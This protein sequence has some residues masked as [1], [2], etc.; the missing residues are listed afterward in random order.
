MA[1][2]TFKA[3]LVPNSDLG[4]SL[5]S[6]CANWVVRGQLHSKGFYGT[7]DID[8]G[9]LLPNTGSEG[10]IFKSE[11]HSGLHGRR[12]EHG[13]FRRKK[14]RCQAIFKSEYDRDHRGGRYVYGLCA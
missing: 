14:S 11:A 8:Y 7:E 10:Q 6:T 13:I 1:N 5:G 3:N 2:M 4:Y 9:G 12:G